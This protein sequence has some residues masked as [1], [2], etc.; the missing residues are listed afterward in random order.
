MI[1]VSGPIWLPNPSNGIWTEFPYL[2]LGWG[3]SNLDC[4]PGARGILEVGAA[5]ATQVKEIERCL[6]LKLE[7]G[8]FFHCFCLSWWHRKC[9]SL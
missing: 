8:K 4:L 3:N 1:C 2:L 6:F 5:G 7:E 9:Q